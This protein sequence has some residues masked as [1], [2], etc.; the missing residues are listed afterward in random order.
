MVYQQW[1]VKLHHPNPFW[2][3]KKITPQP[4]R[5][6]SVCAVE[7]APRVTNVDR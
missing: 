6:A 4:M 5:P 2:V 7:R 3:L 1:H